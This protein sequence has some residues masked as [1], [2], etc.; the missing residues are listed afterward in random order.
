[1]SAFLHS[2]VG[3]VRSVLVEQPGF[4]RTEHS[5]GT[6]LDPDGGAPGAIIPAVISGVRNGEPWHHDRLLPETVRPAA[7]GEA[8]PPEPK[9][10]TTAAEA[11]AVAR[12]KPRPP[13]GAGSP[14]PSGS[15]RL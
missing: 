11:E 6:R 15:S 12:R 2:E 9:P 8:A 10:E 1:M 14:Q 3:G 7:V 13:G 5:L 4:G